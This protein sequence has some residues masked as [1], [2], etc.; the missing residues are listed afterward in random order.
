[1]WYYRG[2]NLLCIVGRVHMVVLELLVGGALLF[3]LL[4]GGSPLWFGGGP[5]LWGLVGLIPRRV[6]VRVWGFLFI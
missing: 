4:T 5:L 1:M 3:G 2:L 6:L